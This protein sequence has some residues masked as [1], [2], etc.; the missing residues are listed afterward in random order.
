MIDKL[1]EYVVKQLVS[2]PAS[3][4]VS[5]AENEGKLVIQ[6]QVAPQDVARVIGSEGRILRSL[7][8][9]GGQVEAAKDREIVIEV[10]K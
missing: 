8:T 10:I 9:I 6:I 7:R 5:S 1:I 4:V 3:V 2:Q